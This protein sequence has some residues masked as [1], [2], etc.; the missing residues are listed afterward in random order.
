MFFL[1]TALISVSAGLICISYDGDLSYFNITENSYRNFQD[2]SGITEITS[3][4]VVRQKY[5][6]H[7][8]HYG[9]DYNFNEKN[10]LN[11]YAFYNPYSSEHDGNVA[12][13]VRGDKFIEHNWSASKQDADINFSAFYILNYKRAYTKPGRK[14]TLVL[15]TIFLLCYQMQL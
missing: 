12:M 7:R 13:Q 9:L 4:Q 3:D 11:L 10:Q 2:S 1:I 15:T 8:F 6:S 5:W 14:I